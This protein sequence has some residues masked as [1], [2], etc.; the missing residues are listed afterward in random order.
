MVVLF[1]VTFI[2]F[3]VPFLFYVV[4]KQEDRV[5]WGEIIPMT[6]VGIIVGFATSVICGEVA[7]TE[8]IST[9]KVELVSLTSTTSI[10]GQSYLLGGYIGEEQVYY[11]SD[12]DVKGVIRPK[13]LPAWKVEIV[14][15]AKGPYLEEQRQTTKATSFWTKYGVFVLGKGYTKVQRYIFHLPKGSIDMTIDTTIKK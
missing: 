4:D 11:Y 9:H 8:S 7:D 1:L 5:G 6:L 15:D 10:K 3:I 2:F 12:K 13:S 14:E